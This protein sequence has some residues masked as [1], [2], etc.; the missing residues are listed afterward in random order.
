MKLGELNCTVD[1]TDKSL[2]KIHL[3]MSCDYGD[4]DGSNAGKFQAELDRPGLKLGS[5]NVTTKTWIVNAIGDPFDPK[6]AGTYVR[7]NAGASVGAGGGVN[8]LTGGFNGKISIQPFSVEGK[9]GLGLELSGQKLEL[10]AA[11]KPRDCGQST[12]GF[13]AVQGRIFTPLALT[14]H[15]IKVRI[16]LPLYS[17]IVTRG[18]Q[19]ARKPLTKSMRFSP[20]GC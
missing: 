18:R 2:F 7:A 10:K 19:A 6:I 17:G 14:A 8:Y 3:V 15:N 4:V 11:A 16:C 12:C 1:S 5:N 20:P 9:I 13:G